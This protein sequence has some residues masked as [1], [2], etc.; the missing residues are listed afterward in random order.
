MFNWLDSLS[1]TTLV[2]IAILLGLAPFRPQP[3][4]VEKIGML[5]QGTL[6]RP[7]DIFDLLLHAT[8][9]IIV[10]AKLLRDLLAKNAVG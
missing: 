7:I 6:T 1:Y 5:A 3:H 8:P 9:I 4:L 2:P 10:L